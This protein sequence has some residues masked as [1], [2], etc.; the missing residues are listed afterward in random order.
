MKNWGYNAPSLGARFILDEAFSYASQRASNTTRVVDPDTGSASIYSQDDSPFVALVEPDPLTDP[1]NQQIKRYVY[2]DG[3]SMNDTFEVYLTYQPPV[4]LTNSLASEWVPLL[5]LEWKTN[6][7]VGN[8]LN[9]T[10][11]Q[12]WFLADPS[13]VMRNLIDLCD[14]HPIWNEIIVISSAFNKFQ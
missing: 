2:R 12:R 3:A 5:R 10:D 8:F 9:K 14:V 4:D 13:Q 11:L 1:M 7:S 6:G